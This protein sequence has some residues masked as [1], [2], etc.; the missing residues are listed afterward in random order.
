MTD[1]ERGALHGMSEAMAQRLGAESGT[2]RST[3]PA[4][5]HVCSWRGLAPQTD[6]SGGKVLQSHPWKNRKRAVQ[7][8]RVAAH[9][10]LPPHGAFGA[11]Y[12]RLTARL[13]PA[14][15]LMATTHQSVRTVSHGRKPRVPYHDIGAATSPQ[16][17][18]ERALQY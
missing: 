13:G 7:A 8:W 6:N 17:V 14:Q 10:V 16:R 15:A 1:A 2:A 18:R 12:R 3:W 5:Q 9:T 11:F 4:E